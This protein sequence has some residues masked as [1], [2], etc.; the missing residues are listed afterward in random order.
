MLKALHA[1]EFLSTQT[2]QEL[3]ECLQSRGNESAGDPLPAP[4]AGPASK[5]QSSG[6]FGRDAP[7][8]DKRQI[9]QRI[10]EDRERHKRSRESVWAVPFTST[11]PIIPPASLTSP[12]E[13]GAPIAWDDDP[14]FEKLWAET[15]ELG[16]DDYELFEEEDQ[17]RRKAAAAHDEEYK[18][19][20]NPGAGLDN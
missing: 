19:L 3:E 6:Q 11:A 16:E 15:S 4:S 14:E 8:L 18:G 13:N 12:G 9:E 10:E 7:R 2:L 17:E 1:K 5:R 20:S